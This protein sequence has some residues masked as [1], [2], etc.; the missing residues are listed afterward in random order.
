MER[1][2]DEIE[3]KSLLVRERFYRD[4]FQWQKLRNSY[5]NDAAKTTINVSW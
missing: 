2:I 1:I 3:I 5:H 4:T